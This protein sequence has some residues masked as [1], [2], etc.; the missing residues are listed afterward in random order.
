MMGNGDHAEERGNDG[1]RKEKGLFLF[2]FF[3]NVKGQNGRRQRKEE[4]RISLSFFI[5]LFLQKGKDGKKQEKEDE[6]MRRKCD[7]K[8]KKTQMEGFL[9]KII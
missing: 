4:R 3:F 9:M 1:K 2:S 7:R 6:T 5:F 8:E